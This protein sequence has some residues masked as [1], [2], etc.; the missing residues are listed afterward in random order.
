[1]PMTAAERLAEQR[2][3]ALSADIEIQFDK[4]A[5]GFRPMVAILQ[6]ARQLAFAAMN[7]LIYADASNADL[8]RG[9]QNEV[10]RYDDLVAWCAEIFVEGLESDKKLDAEVA[11]ELSELILTPEVAREQRALGIHQQGY[12]A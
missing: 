11:N 12:D 6:K 9:Y 3:I 7:S 8:I 10:R 5:S 2:A 1:M 4:S